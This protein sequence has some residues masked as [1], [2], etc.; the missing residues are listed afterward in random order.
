M[1]RRRLEQYE[2]EMLKY[3]MAVGC[4]PGEANRSH[5][6]DALSAVDKEIKRSVSRLINFHKTTSDKYQLVAF[7]S[8]VCGPV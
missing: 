7:S 8:S 1:G 5:I 3:M 4:A 6:A 2:G